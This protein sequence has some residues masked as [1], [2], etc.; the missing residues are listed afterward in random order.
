MPAK[1]QMVEHLGESGLLLPQLLGQA[2]EKP[3]CCRGEDN[4]VSEA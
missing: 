4:A 3:S 2:G 1:P